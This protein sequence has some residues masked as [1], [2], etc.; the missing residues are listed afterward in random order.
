MSG[1][2]FKIQIIQAIQPS[3]KAKDLIRMIDVL[4][5]ARAG[6]RGGPAAAADYQFSAKVLC[7]LFDPVKPSLYREAMPRARLFFQGIATDAEV[8]DRFR[9]A[10]AVHLVGEQSLSRVVEMGAFESLGLETEGL[11][12]ADE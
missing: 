2:D 8:E 9:R 3:E 1:R 11:A 6:V 10:I 4:A 5:E 7:I 12:T